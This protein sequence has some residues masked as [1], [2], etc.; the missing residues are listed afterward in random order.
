V[1]DNSDRG[2]ISDEVED[3][4]HAGCCD[5]GKGLPKARSRLVGYMVVLLAGKGQGR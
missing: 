1:V 4:G 5:H 2:Q 3:L